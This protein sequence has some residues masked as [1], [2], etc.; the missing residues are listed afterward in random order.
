MT[1]EAAG[2]HVAPYH[3]QLLVKASLPCSIFWKTT[4]NQVGTCLC[5]LAQPFLS[6]LS[7]ETWRTACAQKQAEHGRHAI[8]DAKH[9]PDIKSYYAF[10]G[11][12]ARTS[13]G[14]LSDSRRA[15]ALGNRNKGFC[16][17]IL[18]SIHR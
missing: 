7:Q 15:A 6:Q 1:Q 18:P 8:G 13:A 17:Q 9:T 10:K 16:L 4:V 2:Q 5:W 14:L 3:E 11:T 12:S